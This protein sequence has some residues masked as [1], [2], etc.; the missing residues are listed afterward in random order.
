MTLSAALNAR[1][2]FGV[3][4]VLFW[5]CGPPVELAGGVE[6]VGD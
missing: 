1:L 3:V 2:A 5:V 6:L 4:V